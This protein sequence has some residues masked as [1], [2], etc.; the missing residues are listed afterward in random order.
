[1]LA[2]EDAEALLLLIGELQPG[3]QAEIT[4]LDRE[5]R[6]STTEADQAYR[7]VSAKGERIVHIE[8]ES[9]WKNVMPGRMAD[10]GT[11]EWMLYKLPVEC[12]VL[13]LTDRGLPKKPSTIGRIDAGDIQITVQ[14]RII[15][16]SQIPASEALH[17]RR[18]YLLPFVPL[19]NATLR[20]LKRSAKLIRDVKDEKQRGDLGFYFGAFSGVKYNLTDLLS[21]VWRNR[22]D[23]MELIEESPLYHYVVDKGRAEGRAEGR[24]EGHAKGLAKGLTKGLTKGQLE[25]MRNL[26]SQHIARRF[27]TVHVAKKLA[28]LHDV[29]VVQELCLEFNEIQDAVALRKRLDEAIKSQKAK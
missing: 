15:R 5:M 21:L 18:E 20:E 25:A 13:L 10:Y 4:P 11:R 6:I 16:L 3:E 14:Y 24:V 29:A 2:T 1:M 12:Y 7:V 22:M 27:P 23:L 8:A 26:L 9:W 28:Q 19:M 17:L